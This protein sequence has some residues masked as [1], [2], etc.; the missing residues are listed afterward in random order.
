MAK[1]IGGLLMFEEEEYEDWDEEEWEDEDANEA[2][3][4]DESARIDSDTP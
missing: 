3:P 2:A 1:L 4:V